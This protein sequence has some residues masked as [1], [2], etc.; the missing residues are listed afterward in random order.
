MIISHANRYIYLRNPKAAS[1]SIARA[2]VDF[3]KYATDEFAKNPHGDIKSLIR[4]WDE[5][6]DYLLNESRVEKIIS[7][8]VLEDIFPKSFESFTKVVTVRNPWSRFLSAFLYLSTGAG[9]KVNDRFHKEFLYGIT[10]FNEFLARPLHPELKAV[11]H[12]RDQLDFVKGSRTKKVKVQ[13]DRILRIENPE[14][15]NS[16]FRELTGNPKYRTYRINTTFRKKSAEF[17]KPYTDYYNDEQVEIV[18]EFYKDDI[19]FLGYEF[20]K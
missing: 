20:G 12:F 11:M 5:R 18:R 2:L 1:T 9:G 10:D 17:K 4:R 3:D 13:C 19:E 16:T 7:R 14:L 15:I 6:R 8:G